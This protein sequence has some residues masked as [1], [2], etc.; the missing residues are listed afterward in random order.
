M[1]NIRILLEYFGIDWLTGW[2]AMLRPASIDG[3]IGIGYVKCGC[4]SSIYRW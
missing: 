4:I 3:T 1:I 2:L